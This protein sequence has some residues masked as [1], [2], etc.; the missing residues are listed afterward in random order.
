MLK[1]FL[2]FI[3]QGLKILIF[4]Y[5]LLIK[6]FLLT[7]PF[8]I[9]FMISVLSITISIGI[10]TILAFHIITRE[11]ATSPRFYQWFSAHEKM[12]NVITIL[13][14][15]ADIKALD[16]LH[17]NLAGFTF[18]RAPPFSDTAKPKIF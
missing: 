1:M 11:N 16:I 13:A 9:F 4:F 8:H 17:S 10:N 5:P 15:V 7:Y 2:Y 12:A 6:S 14:A 18:F 3:F